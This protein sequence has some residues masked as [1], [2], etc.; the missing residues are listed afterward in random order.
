MKAD[1]KE[2]VETCPA[3]EPAADSGGEPAPLEI[4]QHV[5]D[6]VLLFGD[7]GGVCQPAPLFDVISAL[8]TVDTAAQRHVGIQL[9]TIH[10]GSNAKVE[11]AFVPLVESGLLKDLCPPGTLSLSAREP[12]DEKALKGRLEA[13]LKGEIIIEDPELVNAIH[14]QDVDWADVDNGAA[15]LSLAQCLKK[16]GAKHPLHAFVSQRPF[17]AEFAPAVVHTDSSGNPSRTEDKKLQFRVSPNADLSSYEVHPSVIPYVKEMKFEHDLHNKQDMEE[18]NLFECAILKAQLSRAGLGESIVC[19]SGVFECAGVSGNVHKLTWYMYDL[20]GSVRSPDTYNNLHKEYFQAGI[21]HTGARRKLFQDYTKPLVDLP[22]PP[23]MEAF[24]KYCRQ[25]PDDKIVVHCGGP[26]FL[27]RE[28]AKHE[29]LRIRVILIG[30][31]FLAYDG[32]ANLLG[33]NFNEGVAPVCAE[34]VF[35]EDGKQLHRSFPNARLVCIATETCKCE[36]LAFIPFK[37]EAFTDLADKAAEMEA[38]I[39]KESSSLPLLIMS[40]DGKD[41]DDELCK[42]LLRS[43]T[44]RGLAKCYGCIGNLCPA[45]DRARL[46]RGTLDELGM[47]DVPVAVGGDMITSTAGEYEFDVPYIANLDQCRPH[48]V[49]MFVEI[50]K[51]LKDGQKVSL[52]C[53]SGLADAWLLLKDHRDVFREKIGRVVIMGGVEVDGDNIKLDADGQ[54]MPDK[55]QNNT[56]DFSAAQQFYKEVQQENV[57]LTVVTRWAAYAAKLPFTVYDAMAD[58]GHP[59]GIRLQTMQKHSLSHL[60]TRACMADDD[61]K[62]GGLPGRCDQAWF[63]KIFLGGKGLDR[64]GE[65]SIWDLASTFQAYDPMALLAACFGV[66]ARFMR[67]VV[68]SVKGLRGTTQH[69]VLGVTETNNGVLE[70]EALS[71]WLAS[72]MIDGLEISKKRKASLS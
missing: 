44:Q 14:A 55:A 10:L 53:L 1:S 47:P 67:P 11:R 27:V 31:M 70:G 29:D 16:S 50:L 38:I 52:V 24:F 13:F 8:V 17:T 54:M 26:L 46:A 36:T 57:P 15:V 63:C 66:R 34:E 69:E 59:V 61:P 43:L 39:P 45:K 37:E 51:D 35:G 60:W 68:V 28:L 19:T 32:Q 2:P 42:V 6:A 49:D 62:R 7:R 72:A 41:P 22:T 48:G 9:A 33:R 71:S 23:D 18:L 65:D 58:T 40:D 4:W 56:F 5:R 25:H 30:A 64:K 3:S 12:V 20:D 21:G